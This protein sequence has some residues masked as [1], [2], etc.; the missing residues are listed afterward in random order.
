[1]GAMSNR[2]EILV[3]CITDLLTISAGWTLY[4]L[5]RVRSGLFDVNAEPDFWGPMVAVS[6]F[7]LLLFFVVGLYRPWYAASRFDELALLFKTVLVGSLILFF[8]VFLDDA[9]KPTGTNFRL[10]IAVYWADVL[11]TV[12]T[13]RM[14]LRSIQRRMLIAGIGVHNTLIVGSSERSRELW[15]EVDKYPALGYKVVGFIGLDR[16][17]AGQQHRKVPVMGGIDDLT[18]VIERED[19]REV[20]VA[21]DSADHDRLLDIIGRCNGHRVSIKIMPDLYDIISGQARTN[22]IYG[23]PLIEIT[24]QLMP[25][26]EEATKRLIDVVVS[27]LILIIGLPLWLLTALIIKLDSR[28]PVL[29]RQERVGRDGVPFNI[30]KFRSMQK[31]AEQQGPQWAGHRDPRVTRFGKILRQLHL[32][33]IPQMFNILSGDMSLI[34]PRPER[35]MFVQQLLKEIPLYG[36]RLK[37][38]PGVTGWA[39]VK[40]RYDETIDDVKKK[41]QYDLFYIENMSLRMDFKIILNTAYHVLL[42]RGR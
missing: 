29:Y 26:W 11:L 41:V 38:R 9:G 7:W 21:L 10:L 35:P 22:Q 14:V 4:Y 5:I 18:D 6:A 20:L 24:P 27:A 15:G 1:M 2:R 32:D 42:G 33:E 13:G 12:A 3:L 28:G 17:R 23:F 8:A 39:Q 36:R 40:Q 31:D 25:P 19:V 30:I 37:V 16:R 34:G